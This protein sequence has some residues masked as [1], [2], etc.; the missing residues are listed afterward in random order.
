L[1]GAE[2]SAREAIGGSLSYGLRQLLERMLP[3]AQQRLGATQFAALWEAGRAVAL[4]AA[5]DE[6]V[7]FLAATEQ[8]AKD[9]VSGE[10]A[11][12]LTPREVEVL[13]LLALGQSDRDIA[14]SLFISRHTAMKHVANILAKLGVG[15]RTAAATV[16]LREG[17]A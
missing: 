7:A 9:R 12:G 13:R 10:N 8:T 5:V 4:L 15:S 16:A 1:L 11:H 14:E 2:D 17:L 3:D 6:A